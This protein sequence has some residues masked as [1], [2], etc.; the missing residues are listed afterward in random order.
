MEI[1]FQYGESGAAME[2]LELAKKLGLNEYESRAYLSM[3]RLGTAE[4]SAVSK[5]ASIPRARVYDVLTSLEKRGFIEKKPS[6]PV[7]YVAVAPSKA[8][9]LLKE[10][11]KQHLEKHLGE[12]EGIAAVLEKQLYQKE[13]QFSGEEHAI[14]V[15]GRA[16][17]Y[18][19]L[20][21]LL[22]NS[23]ESAV[24]CSSDEGI[25]RKKQ[26]LASK[27]ASLSRRGVKVKFR[28][29]PNS[30]FAVVDKKSVMLFLHPENIEERQEKALLINSPYIAGFL[31]S[32][33]KK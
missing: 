26:G 22:E 9:S 3:L 21:G 5:S 4:A 8:F 14:L 33:N 17:I 25:A 18:S 20:A 6:K 12:I 32:N 7:A 13:N 31:L 24:I 27:L 16:N 28:R 19:K 10:Q 30:R 29:S 2:E 11:K 15:E 23:Q 1:L